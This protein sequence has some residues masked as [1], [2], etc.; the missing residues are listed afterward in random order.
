MDRSSIANFLVR[1]D[2]LA[3]FR[4][5]N[6]NRLLVLMY[7]RFSYGEE[8][9][10]TSRKTLETHLGYLK[11]N[12]K[13]ISLTD[14][15]SYLRDGVSFPARSAVI[16][17]DDGYRDFCE[18]AFPILERYSMP[19]IMYAV[20]DFIDG[21]DWIWTDKARFI[22]VRTDKA[23]FEFRIND[24]SIRS[25]LKGLD[26]RLTAA[27]KINSELKRLSDERKDEVLLEFSN[28]MSVDIPAL[29]PDEFRPFNWDDA[30]KMQKGVVTI[31]SHTRS[32][33][34][35]TNVEPDRLGIELRAS[36]NSIQENLQ[37]E[38][39]HFCYPNGDVSSRER[40]AAEA[41]GYAS[42][43]TTEIRLCEKIE[44]KFLI[45]RIDA[46]PEMHR[47]VQ[48]TSGF[49]RFKSRAR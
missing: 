49:D 22:L 38:E 31:G 37:K 35:L 8:F 6:R 36:R 18:I 24:T 30:R 40:D 33:P 14:A 39:V 13:I 1:A 20:T 10:K 5:I 26:S 47:F 44:D 46:E 48:A 4:F 29:P 28:V 11:K 3:P 32:H 43:V 41:A 27:G 21:K 19:A 9:G 17:V 12:Y 2:A 45:P 25:S 7:H 23:E 34:I 42:A 15:V 16:T